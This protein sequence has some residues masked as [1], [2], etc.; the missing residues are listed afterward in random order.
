[1]TDFDNKL[2]FICGKNGSD[3]LD[4]IPP[5][6]LFLDKYSKNLLTLPAH[7]KCNNSFSK[8]DEYFRDNV[9]LASCSSSKHANELFDTKIIR[10]FHREQAKGYRQSFID[11][12]SSVEIKTPSDLYIKTIPIKIV[13]EIRI[14]SVIER[15]CRGIYYH[16]HKNILPI[17]CPIDVAML[18]PEQIEIRNIPFFKSNLKTIIPDIFEY[19]MLSDKDDMGNNL[20]VLFFYSCFVFQV[21]TGIV[22]TEQKDKHE[23]IHNYEKL[24]GIQFTKDTLWMPS[25]KTF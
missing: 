11:E 17:N 8:D 5:K 12:M 18:Q 25:G 10:A 4:H 19:V 1:M 9:V 15:I 6:G 20:F 7:Y 21:S 14:D 16:T 22:A 3:T 13:E 2:C 24:E 23:T